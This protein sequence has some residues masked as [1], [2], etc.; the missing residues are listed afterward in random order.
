M[1]RSRSAAFSRG[2]VA[3]CRFAVDRRVQRGIVVH[4]HLPVEFEAPRAAQVS[5]ATAHPGNL[6]GRR[7]ALPESCK[8]L[9]IALRM[10]WRRIPALRLFARVV[11]LQRQNR[12]PV[13]DQP[14]RLGVERGRGFGKPRSSS[15]PALRR[16]SSSTRSLRSWLVRSIAA[17]HV[18]NLRV[19]RAGRPRLVLDVPQIEVRDAAAPRG[20]ASRRLRQRTIRPPP[21]PAARATL[22]SVDPAAQQSPPPKPS[23]A[24]LFL[25]ARRSHPQVLS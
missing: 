14:R 4:L 9:P 15:Q 8:P 7:A 5:P 19:G 24:V 17:L 3:A 16:S 21:H 2:L 12:Q 25:L 11:D 23:L 6:P 20:P 10:P 18:G 22:A 13:D 1:G